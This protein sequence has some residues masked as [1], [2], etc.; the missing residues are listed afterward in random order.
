MAHLQHARCRFLGCDLLVDVTS[1]HVPPMPFTPEI[2]V[3]AR[4]YNG[5][6]ML[7]YASRDKCSSHR[8]TLD[9]DVIYRQVDEH[10]TARAS[11]AVNTIGHCARKASQHPIL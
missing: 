6:Q 2:I 10:L 5:S 1:Y 7:L 9:M 4:V 11:R 3:S 8:K